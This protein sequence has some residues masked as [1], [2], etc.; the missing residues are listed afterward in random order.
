MS[1]EIKKLR[2]EVQLLRDEFA[3]MQRKYEDI[4]Y[5]L[6]DENFS[7]RFVKEKGDMKTAIEVTAEGI[8]TKVSNEELKKYSTIEQTAEH[9]QNIVFTNAS[10]KRENAILTSD[11]TKETDTSQIFVERET[12]STGNILS[13]T[14]YYYDDITKNWEV[15]S[16]EN[17]FSVFE[18]TDKGFKLKGNVLVDGSCVITDTL[19]FSSAS[20]PVDVQYSTT[21][22][23]NTW[24]D[25]FNSGSDKFMR[26]KIGSQWSS[27]MKVVGDDGQDGKDGSSESVTFTKV[28][29]VL[30]HLYKTAN[31]GVPTTVTGSYI[32]SPNVLAGKF[33]GSE[34]YAGEGSGYSQM[35]EGGFSIYDPDGSAKVGIGYIES[36]YNYPYVIL[37]EGSGYTTVGSSVV[38]KLGNGVWIGESSVLSKPGDYPGGYA[39]G[40]TDISD[41]LPNATG[42]F[43]DFNNDKIWKYTK[44]VPEEISSGGSSSGG[45][46]VAVFG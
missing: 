24:H 11:V 9:I 32:Y 41:E 29:A 31:G 40:I 23:D 13:E 25:T 43:I 1:D 3:I 34:F 19:T 33:Y 21:G 39:S 6:D 26:I 18:Q 4:L 46:A 7:S 16:G 44:G 5:N 14:Y 36:Y 37:G 30:G 17:I 10:A 28:N 45:S 38:Y 20:K 27:A 22:A 35:D 8:K 2:N 15:L 42:I 12:D